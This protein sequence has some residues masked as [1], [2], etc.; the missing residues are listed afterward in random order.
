MCLLDL[1]DNLPQLWMSRRHMELTIWI[2]EIIGGQNDYSNP[3]VSSLLHFYPEETNGVV[4][5]FWQAQHLK[6]MPPDLLTPMYHKLF[7]DFYVNEIAELRDRSLIIPQMWVFR[8]GRMCADGYKVEITEDGL[9]VVPELVNIEAQELR[10]NDL[11]LEGYNSGILF[12]L[13]MPNPLHELAQGDK[14]F[15]SFI[16]T[17]ADDVGGNISKLVNAFKNIYLAHV[18]LP[19]HLLQQ[20]FFVRFV[21]MSQHTSTPE[22]FEAVLKVIRLRE[23]NLSPPQTYNVHTHRMCRFRLIILV[24]PADNPQQSEEPGPAHTVDD[25]KKKIREQLKK[26]GEG[27]LGPVTS[28]QTSTGVKDKLAQIWIM[29]VIQKAKQVKQENPNYTKKDVLSETM[30]WLDS[31]PGDPWSPLLDFTGLDPHRDTPVEILHT[32]LLSIIKYVWHNLHTTLDDNGRLLFVTQLQSSSISGLSIPPICTGYMSQY[33]NGL[34]GKHFKTIMQMIMFHMH[35]LVKDSQFELIKAAG[36]LGAVVWYH[37]IPDM[38]EYLVSGSSDIQ[39]DLRVLIG[40]ILDSFNVI[41]PAHIIMK[42][43]IHMLVFECF[44]HIFQMC[45]VLSNHQAP[46]RNIARKCTSMEHVKHI[47]SGGYWKYENDEYVQASPK[48]QE[49]ICQHP[50]I[51]T[52]LGWVPRSDILPGTAIRP[53]K[54]KQITLTW[55]ETVVVLGV[56]VTSVSG[57]VC[58]QESWVVANGPHNTLIVGRVHQ[59]LTPEDHAMPQHVVINPLSLGVALHPAFDMPTV[60]RNPAAPDI[61]FIINVQHDCHT[62]CCFHNGIKHVVQESKVTDHIVDTL[63]HQDD[64]YYMINF[65]ALLHQALPRALT[66]PCPL[67][68][69]RCSFHDSMAASLRIS[70]P[71]K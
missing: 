10:L 48:V 36:C 54:S 22:Q 29:Q 61:S 32:I 37:E 66:Q 26:A 69:D 18:N 21:A 45:S 7:K 42:A 39:C 68:Q 47:A 70:Q 17:W 25:T 57:D 40:N 20:E 65:A 64:R 13:M 19:G 46:G 23:S 62:G 3:Q 1:L 24:L 49:I 15:M 60:T 67:H 58:P 50:I 8:N 11:D 34:I 35:G 2:M 4:T 52:H 5:E 44:N 9:H 31:Q 12:R 51:Q 59:V 28:L 41:D 55:S 43:K 53:P 6:E 63:T 16:M 71:K 14:L 27:K 38:Q 33:H 56:G 30:K